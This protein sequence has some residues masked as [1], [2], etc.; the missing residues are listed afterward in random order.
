VQ[1][2][3]RDALSKSA[4]IHEIYAGAIRNLYLKVRVGCAGN[5]IDFWCLL[6]SKLSQINHGGSS[7]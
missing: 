3:G 6:D 1:A 2:S 4:V 5:S 7:C